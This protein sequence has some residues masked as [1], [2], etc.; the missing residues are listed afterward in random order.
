MKNLKLS[1]SEKSEMQMSVCCEQPDYPYGLKIHLC[2]ESIQKLGVK[3]LPEIGSVIQI[4]AM[5][6]VCDKNEMEKGEEIEMSMGLQITDMAIGNPMPSKSIQ[7][8]LYNEEEE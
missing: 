5:A 4:T 3:K 6:Y 1:D 8:K 2:D 7:D